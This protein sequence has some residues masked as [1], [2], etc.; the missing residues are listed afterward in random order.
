MDTGKIFN[1]PVALYTQAK[2]AIGEKIAPPEIHDVGCAF[3]VDTVFHRAFGSYIGKGGTPQ[4]STAQMLVELE[5]SA[6]FTEISEPRQGCIVMYA[7]GTSSKG[8][9]VHGH[10]LVM[11]DTW[12]MSNNSYTGV[13]E[14]NYTLA[15]A[16][17]YFQ[18]TKGFTPRYFLPL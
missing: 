2:K 6:S 18:D 16:K 1:G 8:P 4:Q 11:G 7:T 5:A 13:F 9:D 17:A 3:C 15:T 10:V 14:A 12:L